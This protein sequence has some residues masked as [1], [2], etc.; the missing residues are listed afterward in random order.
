MSPYNNMK[1]QQLGLFAIEAR[2]K[3]MVD[4]LIEIFKFDNE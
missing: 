3:M 4:K 2:T 1:K